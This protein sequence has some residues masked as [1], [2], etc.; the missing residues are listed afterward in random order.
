M[1]L[2]IGLRERGKGLFDQ[3]TPIQQE[4]E[5]EREKKKERKKEAHKK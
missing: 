1:T 3:T 2:L 4:R 5:R